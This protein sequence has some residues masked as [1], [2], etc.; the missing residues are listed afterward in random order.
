MSSYSDHQMRLRC[1]AQVQERKCASQKR[2][3]QTR[4]SR[5]L[6]NSKSNVRH[7]QVFKKLKMSG[8]MQK[9]V[10]SNKMTGLPRGPVPYPDENRT[11]KCLTQMNSRHRAKTR[12]LFCVGTDGNRHACD[13]TLYTLTI[14]LP[15]PEKPYTLR[16]AHVQSNSIGC[17]TKSDK[18]YRR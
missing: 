12:K 9:K 3:K 5:K 17:Q 13:T 6:L 11:Q 8:F 10:D 14:R 2:K 16:T 1:L 18:V 7:K 4:Q 15:S